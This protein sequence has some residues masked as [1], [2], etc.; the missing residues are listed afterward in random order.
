QAPRLSCTRAPPGGHR[1]RTC[2]TRIHPTGPLT[3]AD[4]ARSAIDLSRPGRPAGRPGERPMTTAEVAVAARPEEVPHLSPWL[5]SMVVMLSTFMEV[6]DTSIANVSLPHIAGS[7]AATIDESTWVL[8]SY[9][10]ANAIVLPL[11]GW[12]SSL[13]GRKNFYMF[14][15][16][17]FTVSSF[18]CG[19]APSLGL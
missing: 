4:D 8:T 18:L 11:S 7:L 14:C 12:V 1:H 3:H 10:V 9:L 13:F 2:L 16:M 5:I 6:L 17:L 15:V 19:F